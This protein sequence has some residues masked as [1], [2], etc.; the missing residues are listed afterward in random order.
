MAGVE[1]RSSAFNDHDLMPERLSK[2][3]GNVSP[4]LRWSGIPDGTEE[5]VLLCEDP[6]AP[7]GEPFLHWLVTG[8]DPK[9]AGVD[10]GQVPQGG[11]EW[12][13]GFGTTG[14]GGP[15]PPKGDNPHRYF[16]RLYAL[17]QPFEVPPAPMAEQ[18][19]RAAEQRELASG[20]LVGTFGR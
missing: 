18:A 20:T 11:Q 6:D 19:R 15:Q 10:E 5:L 17:S 9:T 4:P 14:W 12:P 1:L 13:N 8:I 7:G 3:G 16:F 2:P